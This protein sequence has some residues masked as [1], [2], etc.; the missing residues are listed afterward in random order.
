MLIRIFVVSNDFWVD[1]FHDINMSFVTYTVDLVGQGT[2][3]TILTISVSVIRRA[4]QMIIIFVSHVFWV[5]KFNGIKI[6]FSKYTVDYV[7][8]GRLTTILIIS[9]SESTVHVTE[10]ISISQRNIYNILIRTTTN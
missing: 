3:T 7:G 2:L 10:L 5:D 4:R 9:I 6:N 8:Q 1:T